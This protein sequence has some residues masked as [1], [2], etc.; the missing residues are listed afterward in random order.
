MEHAY[1]RRRRASGGNNDCRLARVRPNMHSPEMD[2]MRIVPERW[3][4]YRHVAAGNDRADGGDTR[5]GYLREHR[6]G[7]PRRNLCAIRAWRQAVAKSRLGSES[8]GLLLLQ[9]LSE[10]PGQRSIISRPSHG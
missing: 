10:L 9:E 7:G 5:P 2:R 4:P 6:M 3:T 1:R 8:R